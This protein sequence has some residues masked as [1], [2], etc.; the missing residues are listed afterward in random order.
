M[1]YL[2]MFVRCSFLFL[3]GLIIIAVNSLMYEQGVSHVRDRFH[4]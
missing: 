3:H 1:L 4:H 2:D